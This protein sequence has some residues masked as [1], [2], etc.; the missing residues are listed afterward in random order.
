MAVLSF[1][2]LPELKKL[3]A[4]HGCV[5]HLHDACGGQS[6]TLEAASQPPTAALYDD[7]ARFF[8]QRGMAIHF[9]DDEKLHFTAV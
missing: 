3:A 8:A 6:F 7:L 5:I 4:Q 2:E 1:L 9:Y